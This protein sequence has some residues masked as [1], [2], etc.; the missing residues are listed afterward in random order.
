MKPLFIHSKFPCIYS[1]ILL[2]QLKTKFTEKVRNTID[3][4]KAQRKL[5]V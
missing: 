4:I 1:L 2:C 5:G 3:E